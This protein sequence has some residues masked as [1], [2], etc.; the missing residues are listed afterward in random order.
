MSVN[1]D[2][3]SVHE[4]DT[5]RFGVGQARRGWLDKKDVLSTLTLGEVRRL[6]KRPA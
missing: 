3:H 5:L 2:A 1:S 4:L 6:L